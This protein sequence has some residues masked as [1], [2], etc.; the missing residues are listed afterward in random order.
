MHEL[1]RTIHRIGFSRSSR[2]SGYLLCRS[3]YYSTSTCFHRHQQKPSVEQ[4]IPLMHSDK[5]IENAPIKLLSQ[6]SHIAVTRG[7]R[8]GASRKLP[9]VPLLICCASGLCCSGHLWLHQLWFSSISPARRRTELPKAVVSGQRLR[10]NR[11]CV[12]VQ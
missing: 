1:K 5:T 10:H 6:N 2:P 3:S 11:S 8:S 7:S 12:T 9:T 4:S